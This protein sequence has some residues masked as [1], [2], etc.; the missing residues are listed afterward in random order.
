MV[1]R[2]SVS[3]T[4]A[5][6]ST[7]ILPV[8]VLHPRAAT[9]SARA[10]PGCRRLK[11]LRGQDRRQSSSR[12]LRGDRHRLRVGQ[13][14]IIR[15]PVH[16]A[17]P[18]LIVVPHAVLVM[19][20]LIFVTA[21]KDAAWLRTWPRGCT[22]ALHAD[23]ILMQVAPERAPNRIVVVDAGLSLFRGVAFEAEAAEFD[24]HFIWGQGRD[25]IAA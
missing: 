6:A 20:G 9:G 15:Q 12:S 11:N 5:A 22:L 18:L 21:V 4:V 24:H 7:A 19:D 3:R 14:G 23:Q 8:Q 10:V 13:V 2:E 1:E 25:D 16:P 17:T